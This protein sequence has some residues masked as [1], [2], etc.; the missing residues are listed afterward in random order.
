MLGSK[1]QALVDSNGKLS[2]QKDR[3]MK[4]TR[5]TMKRK[6]RPYSTEL[7]LSTGFQSSRRMFKQTLPS[8]SILG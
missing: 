4:K 7:M 2:D 8:K 6:E 5:L 3:I 1:M